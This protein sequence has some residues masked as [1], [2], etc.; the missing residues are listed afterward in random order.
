MK[1]IHHIAATALA[2]AL[3]ASAAPAQQRS[4]DQERSPHLGNEFGRGDRAR[5]LSRVD[6]QP[7]LC[8][9]DLNLG[10]E[11]TK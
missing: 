5:D 10:T 6:P 1:L 11:R 9:V 2:L 3:G 8:P 7:S 4:R